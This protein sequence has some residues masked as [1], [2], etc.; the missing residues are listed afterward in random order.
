MHIS[1]HRKIAL[2]AKGELWSEQSKPGSIAWQRRTSEDITDRMLLQSYF[3]RE[4]GK[5]EIRSEI[6]KNTS[7]LLCFVKETVSAMG[8]KEQLLGGGKYKISLACENGSNFS[9]CSPVLTLSDRVRMEVFERPDGTLVAYG[10]KPLEA[11]FA[12]CLRIGG[13]VPL[14][15]PEYIPPEEAFG[16]LE[17]LKQ[18]LEGRVDL[19]AAGKNERAADLAALERVLR[20]TQRIRAEEYAEGSDG[21]RRADKEMKEVEG[22]VSKIKAAN[23]RNASQA[24]AEFSR[25]YDS[26]MPYSSNKEWKLEPADAELLA[27]MIDQHGSRAAKESLAAFIGAYSDELEKN[28]QAAPLQPQLSDFLRLAKIAVFYAV[29]KATGENAPDGKIASMSDQLIELNGC[30]SRITLLASELEG[31]NFAFDS[32]RIS[33]KRDK[34]EAFKAICEICGK[35]KDIYNELERMKAGLGSLPYS[36]S[37]K[38]LPKPERKMNDYMR[39]LSAV[40]PMT[41][42][43]NFV[44]TSKGEAALWKGFL[45]AHSALLRSSSAEHYPKIAASIGGF[46]KAIDDERAPCGITGERGI[47]MVL[48]TYEK[49][50]IRHVKSMEKYAPARASALRGMLDDTASHLLY[51]L[52]GVQVLSA[53]LGFHITAE[54][55]LIEKPAAGGSAPLLGLVG[56]NRQLFSILDKYGM[57]EQVLEHIDRF[58]HFEPN[59]LDSDPDFEKLVESGSTGR[60]LNISYSHYAGFADGQ[61]GAGAIFTSMKNQDSFMGGL[62]DHGLYPDLSEAELAKI[63]NLDYG[64]K[65]YLDYEGKRYCVEAK[66]DG[67]KLY[68]QQLKIAVVSKKFAHTLKLPNGIPD[69]AD[70]EFDDHSTDEILFGAKEPLDSY[71]S[72][73]GG[74]YGAGAKSLEA[75]YATL[76]GAYLGNISEYNH[77]RRMMADDGTYEFLASFALKQ[78]KLNGAIFISKSGEITY[79]DP[80]R[81]GGVNNLLKGA[82]MSDEQMEYYLGRVGWYL[83]LSPARI[84][85]HAMHSRKVEWALECAEKIAKF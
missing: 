11:T 9:H 76:A 67:L 63:V 77:L 61:N 60:V 53:S 42:A 30:I 8:R 80:S 45:A 19:G 58:N 16:R 34:A 3:I 54:R 31:L 50:I 46:A 10:A 4:S 48:R 47:K 75:A 55:I 41:A 1:F 49:E 81:L 44:R 35:R 62:F 71:L 26:A 57:T 18:H 56:Q 70:S 32:G 2:L 22:L 43:H 36:L 82:G 37:D 40:I 5:T 73:L 51:K 83:K 23:E 14:P 39:K 28:M 85:L 20:S 64:D 72:G 78:R 24:S 27:Q 66:P 59:A 29:S 68:P 15:A 7:Q 65:A 21:G 25:I 13:Y 69:Y 74:A 79:N 84:M 17:R 52:G 6:V 38:S 33:A 12:K